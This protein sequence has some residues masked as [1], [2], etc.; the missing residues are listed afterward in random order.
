MLRSLDTHQGVVRHVVDG[1]ADDECAVRHVGVRQPAGRAQRRRRKGEHTEHAE[2]DRRPKNPG[3][4]LAPARVGAV[5]DQAHRKIRDPVPH[6]AHQQQ[7][8]Y[9]SRAQPRGI[10]E[11]ER[12]E[13]NDGAPDEI[14]GRVAEGIADPL[15]PGNAH[16]RAAAFLSRTCGAGANAS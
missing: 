6:A 2:R 9:R 1:I 12:Q 14:G 3:P 5:D 15:A 8:A 13:H 4:K 10:G 11:K 7:H 16:T